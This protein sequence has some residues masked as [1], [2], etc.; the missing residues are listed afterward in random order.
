MRG[1]QTAA[2]DIIADFVG[3]HRS[4]SDCCLLK[5]WNVTSSPKLFSERPICNYSWQWWEMQMQLQ[6]SPSHQLLTDEFSEKPQIY[7]KL[8]TFSL[9][10]HED[11]VEQFRDRREK[12]IRLAASSSQGDFIYIF[13]LSFCLLFYQAEDKI[14]IQT[15]MPLYADRPQSSVGPG[16]QHT[17]TTRQ[18]L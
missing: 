4:G 11:S 18:L 12:N 5:R 16:S 14:V 1:R 6:L 7:D 15:F 9:A 8:G 17:N 2:R 10:G 3:S 13:F